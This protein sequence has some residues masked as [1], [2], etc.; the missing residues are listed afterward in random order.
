MFVYKRRQDSLGTGHSGRPPVEVQLPQPDASGCCDPAAPSPRNHHARE[1]F[2]PL[3]PNYDRWSRWLSLGQDPRWRRT[4]VAGLDLD[5]GAL[6]ADVATGTGAVAAL[7]RE[8]GC[9]VIAV[10]QSPEMLARAAARG[11]NVIQARAEALPFDDASLDG[12]TFTYL[13][14][15][16]DDPL[17]CMCELARVLRPGAMIGMVEFGLPRGIWRPA[18]VAYTRL[19]LPGVGMLIS[20][21]WRRAGSFLGPS[22]EEFHRRFPDH[23]LIDL[24]EQAGF[25]N[26]RR[27]RQS[28]GGGLIMW[29]R[30]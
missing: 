12:L 19:V 6:V 3:A 20:P 13:L 7:L 29:G 15:Y 2:A 21:G 27:R 5:P 18:W 4:L 1:L 25:S 11:F 30:R 26:V 24:W 14:R 16:V 28:L 17:A 23:A 22:I 8:R 9:R 10:D